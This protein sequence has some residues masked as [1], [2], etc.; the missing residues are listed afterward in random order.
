MEEN[1]DGLGRGRGT[2]VLVVEGELF[3]LEGTLMG[4]GNLVDSGLSW[5]LGGLQNILQ[6]LSPLIVRDRLQLFLV[7]LKWMVTHIK[8]LIT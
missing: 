5:Q 6:E 4:V 2:R 7:L 8:S 1:H 3:E